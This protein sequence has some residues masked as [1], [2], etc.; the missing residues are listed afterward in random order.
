MKRLIANRSINMNNEVQD[1]IINNDNRFD[2]EYISMAKKIIQKIRIMPTYERYYNLAQDIKN[3]KFDDLPD[4]NNN[5]DLW[6]ERAI[7]LLK[8]DKILLSERF[9]TFNEIKNI[10]TKDD[11]L[12]F[13]YDP[14]FDDSKFK[15]INISISDINNMDLNDNDIEE[16]NLY[17]TEGIYEDMDIEQIGDL[18]KKIREGIKL[19]PIVLTKNNELIDGFH[20]CWAYMY[21]GIDNISAFKEV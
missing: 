14:N 19:S 3:G 1:F 4:I 10:E 12:F 9:Y 20:R 7:E 21:L 5:L 17:L 16:I 11:H 8:K 18:V 2:N 13:D 15:L 6:V